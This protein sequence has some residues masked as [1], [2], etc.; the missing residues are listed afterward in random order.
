MSVLSSGTYERFFEEDGKRYHHILSTESGFPVDN[1]LLSVTIVSEKAV[2]ADALST[3]VFALGWE[4][5]IELIT[6]VPGAEGIFVFDDFSVR[7]TPGIRENFTL[8]SGVY[9]LLE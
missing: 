6:S 5:G 8:T 9:R 7:L 1:G 2:I 3:A 4:R